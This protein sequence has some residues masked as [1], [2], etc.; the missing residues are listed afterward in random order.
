MTKMTGLDSNSAPRSAHQTSLFIIWLQLTYM[1]F[2]WG[3]ISIRACC[4]TWRFCS[5]FI[6]IKSR[7]T[8]RKSTLF[9]THRV[10]SPPVDLLCLRVSQHRLKYGDRVAFWAC[11]HR[12]PPHSHTV[13]TCT[14]C[15][16][17]TLQIAPQPHPLL[18]DLCLPYFINSDIIC[19]WHV[20]R[21]FLFH[22]KLKLNIL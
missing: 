10:F 20:G 21:V 5:D 12:F 19:E 13:S 11:G 2:S 15:V 4:D 3:E 18:P 1:W 17:L 14:L 8:G 6:L 22:I 7:P 9:S 16:L